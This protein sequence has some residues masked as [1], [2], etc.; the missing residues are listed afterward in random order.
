LPPTP[1]ETQALRPEYL[2]CLDDLTTEDHRPV[3]RIFI[4]KQYRLLT[5]SLYASW[6]GPGPGRSFLVLVNVGWFYKDENPPVA[7]DCLLSLDVACPDDLHEKEGHSY[8]QWKQGKPPEVVIEIVSDKTGGEETLKKNLYARQRVAYY[9]VFDPEQIL[10]D[11]VLRIWRLHGNQYEAIE[12]GFWSDIG[13]GLTLWQGHFEGHT[14]TW[15]RWCDQKGEVI[16]TGEE[17]AE[18]AEERASK[19]EERIRELEEALRQRDGK[20]QDQPPAS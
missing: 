10:S 6:K 15:L 2:P 3:E 11:E 13:L 20:S 5:R 19:A 8:Y 7:P 4:E 9:A 18:K 16:P 1:E 14:D 17:R 12:P